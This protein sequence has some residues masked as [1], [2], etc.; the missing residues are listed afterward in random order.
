MSRNPR[1]YR[2]NSIYPIVPAV[3]KLHF[4]IG[5]GLSNPLFRS[6]ASSLEIIRGSGIKGRFSVTHALDSDE[7][8]QAEDLD[9]KVS[10]RKIF[11][12]I[13]EENSAGPAILIKRRRVEL[14]NQAKVGGRAWMFPPKLIK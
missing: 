12:K 2:A 5:L 6:R 13:P 8:A 9:L 4:E 10:N 3:T 11:I 1:R 14:A 7:W